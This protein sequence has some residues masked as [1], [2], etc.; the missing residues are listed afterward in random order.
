MGR[1]VARRA[2]FRIM[3]HSAA[4]PSGSEAEAVL[5]FLFSHF[6][7]LPGSTRST[8]S[9]TARPRPGHATFNTLAP[10]VAW[11]G[12]MKLLFRNICITKWCIGVQRPR[13]EK[14]K[15]EQPGLANATHSVSLHTG[16]S[17]HRFKPATTLAIAS[18][19]KMQ[20]LHT[21]PPLRRMEINPRSRDQPLYR[22]S[23]ALS[24]VWVTIS[25]K[26]RKIGYGEFL[27]PVLFI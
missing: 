8:R 11:H 6:P 21:G 19:W 20:P 16:D 27:E 18:K 5:K 17:L 3:H 9:P 7:G 14:G 4:W 24:I 13:A 26:V 10:V 25:L 12:A 22:F 15:M 1:E 23:G 2:S